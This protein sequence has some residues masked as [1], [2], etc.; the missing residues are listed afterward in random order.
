MEDDLVE[1]DRTPLSSSPMRSLTPEASYGAAS[2]MAKTRR[3]P[4]PD[5]ELVCS[6]VD[7]AVN[8]TDFPLHTIMEDAFGTGMT[9]SSYSDGEPSEVR[10]PQPKPKAK[11]KAKAKGRPKAKARGGRR[12]PQSTASK[13]SRKVKVED[14][15]DMSSIEAPHSPVSK[16]RRRRRSAVSSS[17]SRR[18]MKEEAK[19]GEMVLGTLRSSSDRHMFQHRMPTLTI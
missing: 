6:G 1:L 18:M 12:S 5:D 4:H 16:N 19:V 3:V 13:R 11:S 17:S 10:K 8:P 2:V 14:D 9:I 7:E 15:S